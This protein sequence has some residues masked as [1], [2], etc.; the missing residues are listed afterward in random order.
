[1][2]EREQRHH[3]EP[4]RDSSHHE[5]LPESQGEQRT[6]RER[7]PDKAPQVWI[8]SLADYNNGH[9]HGDWVDAAVEAD[10]LE[11]AAWAILSTSQEPAAEEWAIFDYDG[12]GVWKVGEY[13]SL[14]LVARVA[15]GI[16]EHG[17][18][19]AAWADLVGDDLGRLDDF[20]EAYLGE[21]DSA[22]AW[23]DEV[24]DDLG[25]RQQ[26]EELPGDIARY[27]QLDTG[28]WA[29]DAWLGG[30]ITVVATPEGRVWIFDGRV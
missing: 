16:A 14:A 23:A 6:S 15:R 25:Y 29:R 13:E 30:D 21:Y 17:L 10:E 1:M 26:L 9:L 8:G 19:F 12:F 3:T 18:A 5:R 20:A 4:E 11:A 27:V 2:S 28:Q 22:E 7:V 24:M